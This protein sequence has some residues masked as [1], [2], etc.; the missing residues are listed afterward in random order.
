MLMQHML[1]WFKSICILS[2]RVS[3][4]CTH[5]CP[6]FEL[7]ADSDSIHKNTPRS[8]R[9]HRPAGG[10]ERSRMGYTICC[11][12]TSSTAF[13]IVY[14]FF[15]LFPVRNGLGA[16]THD[17]KMR[18]KFFWPCLKS[19]TLDFPFQ[20]KTAL[21]LNGKQIKMG[22]LKL[23]DGCYLEPGTQ[24]M[25]SFFPQIYVEIYVCIYI[26]IIIT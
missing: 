3:W 16:W 15:T 1:P 26:Y 24:G 17:C 25:V 6:S 11:A 19:C 2:V 14:S 10:N 8:G 23:W 21:V 4:E 7:L 20:N 5:I 22:Q 13:V 9:R 12:L 18:F